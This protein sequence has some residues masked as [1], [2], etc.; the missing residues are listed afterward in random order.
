MGFEPESEAQQGKQ[1]FTVSEIN[2]RIKW[3]IEGEWTLQS[4]WVRGEISQWDVNEDR[5]GRHRAF[6]TLRDERSQL[7][8]VMWAAAL[9]SLTVHPNVGETVCVFGSIQVYTRGGVYQIQAESLIIE[10]GAGVWWQRYEQT[11][12]KLEA[13]GLF[14]QERKRAI[15]RFPQQVG[16]IT[17]LEGVVLHDIL[18]IARERHPGVHIVVF[19]A[20]VQGDDAPESLIAAI[21]LANS[22][23]VAQCVGAIDVLIL[24]RGGGSIEDLW[25]FNE[26]AVVRAVA[27]SR[28][29]IISAVGHETDKVLTDFAADWCAPTPSVAAQV[30]FP[31]REELRANL[32]QLEV[33]I[34]RATRSLLERIGERLNNA[35][36]RL[37]QACQGALDHRVRTLLRLAERLAQLSPEVQLA[38]ARERLARMDRELFER[39]WAQL[40]HAHERLARLGQALCACVENTL[41]QQHTR[42]A[43]VAA[44]LDSL[45]PFAVLQRGYAL[46]RDP[47]THG[48]LTQVAQ[49]TVNQSVE[50]VLADGTLRATITEVIPHDDAIR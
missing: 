7:S 36:L 41:K 15:P 42:L 38:H 44:K 28:I 34:V 25:A 13:E 11:K 20:S 30:V 49:F 9:A 4:L 18:R 10:G 19:P 31:S 37:R 14:A 46:L 32:R 3:H 26:E 6:F 22:P 16:V 43:T 12:Q 48:V 45:S 40:A 1:V 24:A 5:Y 21:E 35:C 50:I 29:P 47:Q 2:H 33:R 23:V 27:H 8:G 39:V 17:S